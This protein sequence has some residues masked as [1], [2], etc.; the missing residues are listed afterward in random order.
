[1]NRFSNKIKYGYIS[2][3]A[4]YLLNSFQFGQ[5]YN[6]EDYSNEFLQELKEANYIKVWENDLFKQFTLIKNNGSN[7]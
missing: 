2:R 1:M 4:Y 3:S 7:W 5:V 6:Y